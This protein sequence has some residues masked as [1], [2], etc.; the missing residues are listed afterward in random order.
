MSAV[1]LS[2]PWLLVCLIASTLGSRDAAERDATNFPE[3]VDFG[4]GQSKWSL[5]SA[6]EPALAETVSG[7][8]PEAI[9]NG[10]CALRIRSCRAGPL[11]L[12]VRKSSRGHRWTVCRS[13]LLVVGTVARRAERNSVILSAVATEI[14]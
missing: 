1:R 14:A 3:N 8:P 2:R 5:S 12:R 4:A 7:T 13:L 10:R 11:T 9:H 6:Y